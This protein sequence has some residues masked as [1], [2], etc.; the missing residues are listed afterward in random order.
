VKASA[1]QCSLS[2]L[3]KTFISVDGRV[4]EQPYLFH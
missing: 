4:R 3:H 2:H 1:L